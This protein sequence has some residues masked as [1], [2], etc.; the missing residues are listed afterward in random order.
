MKCELRIPTVVRLYDEGVEGVR[1][2]ALGD[3]IRNYFGIGKIRHIILKKRV[4]AMRGLELDMIATQDALDAVRGP[5][6]E[7]TCDIILTSRLFAT[8]GEGNRPHI[9]TSIYSFPS[10]IST[11]GI[12]EGP[13]K[14]REYYLYK[15]R[16]ARLGI[17]DREAHR[18]AERFKGQFI[19]YGD[20][21]LTEVIK[22][23]VAQAL[24]FFMTGNP[25]CMRKR[26]RLYNAHWQEDMIRAQ[27]GHGEFCS[28]HRRMLARIAG[29]I[30][31][32]TA[33]SR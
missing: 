14:P 5:M 17:W 1:I 6:Q 18:I 12:V 10:I 24:F 7:G 26:C 15:Q 22:G 20:P 19:D 9:R 32:K 21:R 4:V 31:R 33:G 8:P 16:Y 23:Y 29:E 25:F 3:F 13:A 27:M 28:A 11:S 2:P 30:H